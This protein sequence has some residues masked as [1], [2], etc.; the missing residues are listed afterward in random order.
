MSDIEDMEEEI[1]SPVYL[2]EIKE[3][4]EIQ[5]R[6][7]HEIIA[8]ILG[9]GPRAIET[10]DTP[11]YYGRLLAWALK[12]VTASPGWETISTHGY[13]FGEPFFS[14]IQTD[15]SAYSG[16]LANGLMLGKR[17]GVRMAIT[18]NGIGSIQIEASEDYREE[19]N[20]LIQ[21]IKD[22]VKEHNF[23][24]GKRINFNRMISF[25]DLKQRHWDSVV[26]DSEMKNSIRLNTIG[27]LKNIARVQ[28]FGIPA[29][30]GIILTGDPGTGKTI[31]CKALMS[32]AENITCIT[33]DAYGEFSGEYI[34][35][36]YS[37]A[38]DLSPSIIFMEDIDFIGQERHDFYRGT[39]P[40]LTLLAEMDGITEKTAIVTVATSN[41]FE[42]LD[43]ALSE[44]PS[45]FDC[46]YKLPY[47]NSE[48]RTELVEK[49]SKEISLSENIKK[50][51]VTQ[52][53]GFTPAQVQSV[54]HHMAIINIAMKEET[55]QYNRN[56]VDSAVTRV[57]HKQTRPI[58]LRQHNDLA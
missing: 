16:C 47:P 26:L 41:F 19:V 53:H 12:C 14:D 51:V 15:Y 42:T 20:T 45:R 9:K 24:R 29:K 48:Q 5:R 13:N 31:I 6:N 33:T 55:M 27:F 39:P 3:G 56:D 2:H 40:L 49:L 23:Y 44:R 32:E 37:L 34:S 10:F 8:K 17:E 22:Y 4:I 7:N 21:E 58:G 36:L 1:F 52:T 28:E 46:V 25:L 35:D 57:N 18:L 11:S 30:R 54:L 50:Y 43:K 38:Q